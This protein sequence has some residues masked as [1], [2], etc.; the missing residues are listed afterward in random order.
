MISSILFTLLLIAAIA[1]FYRNVSII[2]KN[3]KLGKKLAIKDNKPLRWKTM[4]LVAIGQSQMRKRPLAGLLHIVVY[5]GFIIVNIEMI[6][7]LIDGVAGTHRVLGFL[8]FYPLLISSFEVLAVLV[9]IACVLFLVRRNVL[10]IKRFHSKEM[11]SWPRLDANIILIVEIILMLAFLSMN[12]ADSLLQATESIPH[13]TTGTFL[14]SDL[15]TP[16]FSGISQSWLIVIERSAWWVHI[17]GVL[18]FLN[19]VPY[20]KH[21]HIFLAFPNVYYSKLKPLTYISN[22]DSVTNEVK[23]AM[24]LMEESAVPDEEVGVFGAKD[25]RDLSWKSLMDAYSCTECGRCTAVC[26]AHLTG[27]KLSPRKVVMDTRDRL[28]EIGKAIKASDNKM[29]TEK[30]LLRDFITE[31]EIWA[32]TTCNACTFECPV[33]IDP[34]SIIVELR[35]YQ[36]MEESSAPSSLNAMS[37]NIENNG[38]PWQYSAADRGNWA[39]ELTIEQQQ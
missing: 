33:N 31:E 11:T 17:I 3:I 39:Q 21:F 20:S 1:L 13:A 38:A 27:K 14:I 19:Y 22:M 18:A 15:L 30:S 24:G 7:I 35:R 29:I 23:I 8:P 9:I 34:V 10:K 26:P 12:T 36:F 37:T 28:E 6:E 5:L 25:V 2:S 32:C 4:F 16:V